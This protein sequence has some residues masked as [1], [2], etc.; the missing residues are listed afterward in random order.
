VLAISLCGCA[1]QEKRPLL[2]PPPNNFDVTLEIQPAP[3][4]AGYVTTVGSNGKK[5]AYRFA[6]G[7][8]NHGNV[9]VQHGN[10]ADVNIQITLINSPKFA[11]QNIDTSGDLPGDHQ[12]LFPQVEPNG[13]KGK[14]HDKNNEKLDASYTVIVMD[15]NDPANPVIYCHPG[16]VNN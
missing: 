11:M 1:Q 3:G 5:Y 16:I 7:N 9:K 10:N 6:G 13:L 2:P 12:Q 4:P 15:Q 8:G 14:I